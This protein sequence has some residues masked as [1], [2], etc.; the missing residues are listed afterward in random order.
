M[1]RK[2]QADALFYKEFGDMKRRHYFSHGRIEIIGNHTDHNNGLCLVGGSTLGITASACK[3]DLDTVSIASTGYKPYKIDLS[4]LEADPNE[5]GTSLA[6]TKG[7]LFALKKLGYKIGG[8]FAALD[9]DI[10]AGS[11]VSSSA[12]YE[13]LIG[14]I[15]ND[16]YNDGKIPPHDL[17]FASQYAEVLFF[18]KPCGM[19]DQVGCC[20]GGVNYLDFKDA[21]N[22]VIEPL[23]FD[24]PLT[25]VLVLT[26]S[27]HEG[28]D[29]LY[30]SIPNDM[31][32]V[33][34]NV[35][36][37]KVL[38]EV[39]PQDFFKYIAMPTVG[40]SEIAKLRATHYIDENK[41]VLDA[42]RAILGHDIATF[43]HAIKM[44]G[45]SSKTMLQ[46]TMV[47]GRYKNSPQEAVDVAQRFI[48]DGACRIMGGGFAGSI[49]C[50][51]LPKDKDNFL[52]A[53]RRIYG[54]KNVLEQSFTPGGAKMIDED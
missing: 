49:L 54:E 11:G 9:S 41:R 35:F 43:L 34:A 42:R 39:D 1:I 5:K 23:E 30:A 16:L 27:S 20:Y 10:P 29:A 37:K 3:N 48:G 6:L 31:K 24:L 28:L 53:M 2:E 45:E 15:I 51:L 47:P 13:A 46:N 38:R 12:C 19:L 25:P 22:P 4:S 21:Q 7:V 26:K 44:S 32:S 36:G 33:A 52:N 40:V 18:G 50:F 17:A 8:F 14:E